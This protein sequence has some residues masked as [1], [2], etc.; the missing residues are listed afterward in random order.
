MSK[1]ERRITITAV[2]LPFLGFL[3]AI[4]LLWNN[5]VNWL[6]LGI[7]A[8]MYVFTGA[9]I[10]VGYHRLLTHRSFEAKRWV[11]ITLAIAGSM[12]VQGAP[13]HWVADHRKHHDFTDEEGDPHSPHTHDH[14]GVK[15][16][17]VGWY[18]SHMGWLFSRDERA[19][20]SRYARDLKNDPDIVWVDKH[21]FSWVLLGLA[22]PFALGF[23]LGGF[24]LYAGF[25]AM[26][27]GGFVRI[28][29]QHHAT[30]SVNSI[31]HMYG[32]KPFE[33][34]DQSTNNWAVAFVA[35][36][37][38][39]HH[40]HHAFPTSAR[41]GLLERQVDPA[42]Y[43]IRGLE[44]AGLAWNVKVPDDA[45]IQALLR[46]NDEQQAQEEAADFAP[47]RKQETDSL[48]ESIPDS[49][50]TGSEDAHEGMPTSLAASP[51]ADAT[52]VEREPQAVA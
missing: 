16:V 4:V 41:H 27:W 43:M 22:I 34:E 26:I 21:F 47:Q 10:T 32:D 25:T 24:T 44:K 23:L 12:S 11:K 30:W 29:L 14:T 40:N 9:G 15:G 19:S 7:L 45:Q 46:D 31:C 37:E 49:P 1:L 2:V 8:A 52:E 50:A 28:F 3:V 13:I 18:H 51:L 48:A 35:L 39:W 5:G 38:G 36:G 42:Y 20:A 6:D 17:F 33:L